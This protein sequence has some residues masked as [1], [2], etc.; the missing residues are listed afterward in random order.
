MPGIFVIPGPPSAGNDRENVKARKEGLNGRPRGPGEDGRAGATDGLRGRLESGGYFPE[1]ATRLAP[2]SI[3][4]RLTSSAAGLTSLEVLRR[5]GSTAWAQFYVPG[6]P[7]RY[8]P[9][10]D[11]VGAAGY[12]TI[13][14]SA[15][16]EDSA[17]SGLNGDQSDNSKLQAGARTR[18]DRERLEAQSRGLVPNRLDSYAARQSRRRRAVLR[19]STE[20]LAHTFRRDDGAWISR[21]HSAPTAEPC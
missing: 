6:T 17:A 12:D 19:G 18:P 3:S 11:R 16:G 5:E 9:L 21:H 1:Y 10:I 2:S 4:R 7:A 13:V 8:E 15:D 14:I 20:A